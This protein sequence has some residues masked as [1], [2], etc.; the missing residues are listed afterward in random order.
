MI[1]VYICILCAIVN[2]PFFPNPANLVSFGFC[3]GMAIV[4]L[5]LEK[6]DTNV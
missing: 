6:G 5:L 3:L 2:V 1:T 4:N